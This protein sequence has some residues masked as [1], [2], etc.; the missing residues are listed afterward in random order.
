MDFKT[1]SLLSSVDDIVS[2]LGSASSQMLRHF[3]PD[4]QVNFSK[5]PVNESDSLVE[6]FGFLRKIS[7]GVSRSIIR[8]LASDYYLTL[9]VLVIRWLVLLITLNSFFILWFLKC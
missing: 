2:V 4:K 9:S 7:A 8:S 5:L 3:P 1:V 6:N